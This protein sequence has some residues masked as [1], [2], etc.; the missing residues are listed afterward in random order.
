MPR[1][2]EAAQLDVAV[3]HQLLGERRPAGE[4][5]LAAAVPLVHHRSAREPGHLAVLGEHHVQA[6]R[7]LH[8]PAHQQRVLHAVAVVGE[9]PH[10]GGDE[11]AER[12]QL[13]PARPTVMQPAGS[14]SHSP[15]SLALGAHELDDARESCAGS[16]FGIAT[17]AV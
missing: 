9:D 2:G 13:L 8:R 7:V 3:D 16:V 10:A 17:T 12:R 14:T 1:P 4:A 5:E 6:E 11:L 15:A